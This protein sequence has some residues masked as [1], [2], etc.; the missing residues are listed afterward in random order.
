MGGVK[1]SVLPFKGLKE[2][3]GENDTKSALLARIKRMFD[4]DGLLGAGLIP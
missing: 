2:K 1:V 4:P 3:E